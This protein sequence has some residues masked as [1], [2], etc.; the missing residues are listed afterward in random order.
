MLGKR[1]YLTVLCRYAAGDVII[2]YSSQIYH[3][4]DTFTP[5]P[6]TK[7]MEN[8]HITPGRIGTVFFFPKE[9]LDILKGKSRRW[10][11]LTGFGGAEHL[12]PKNNYYQLETGEI[13]AIGGDEPESSKRKRH[14]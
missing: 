14:G 3:K 7:D 2:F 13:E 4:V 11:A 6:Q 8:Q 9:S 1:A 12:L 10:G 5:L